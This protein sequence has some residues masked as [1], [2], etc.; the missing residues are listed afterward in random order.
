MKKSWLEYKSD[1][2]F[3]IHNLPFGIHKKS[4]GEFVALSA[5]GEF[6]IDLNLLQEN[7]FFDNISLPKD[8]F[9][10]KN[11][12]EFIALKKDIT[13]AVRKKLIYLFDEQNSELKNSDNVDS[14]LIPMKEL[15]MQLPVFIQD[16]TDFYSSKE[17][18]T[19]LGKMFRDPANALL[20]NWL[21][22]PVGYHG[23][24]SS[25]IPSGQ[26]I[27]RP[28]GQVKTENG[29]IFSK[30][31]KL[32]FEL[33]M[34]F[35]TNSKTTLGDSISINDAEDHIFGM[36]IFNDWSARD[37]QA[38]EYVPLGPFLGKSFGSSM[39]PWVV[40][41]E[42]LDNFR[43]EGPNQD[44]KPLDYLISTG[45][46]NYD[47]NLEVYLQPQDDVSNLICSSN[48]KYMY[49]SMAQ[50]LTHHTVNGCNINVGDLMASGT[51]SWK[52]DKSFGSMI[53][54]SWNGKKPFRTFK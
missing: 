53:E 12:N 5:I 45:N 2:D 23:R 50:Q 18:A 35:I 14:I 41:M 26:N 46:K 29:P 6:G 24:A 10:N 42:A 15:N 49:W 16:Y 1:S 34:A 52:T 43:V 47:I 9:K 22:I 51:L 13:N 21:H 30:S 27:I 33:E 31:N 38:W 17:H 8:I 28:K 36:V 20:P 39:S 44:P 7:N 11:L 4:N 32:D 3:S 25:I 19:N 54:L 40:T 37:I 48:H